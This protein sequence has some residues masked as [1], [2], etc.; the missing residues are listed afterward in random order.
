MA[1]HWA[2]RAEALLRGDFFSAPARVKMRAMRFRV[3]IATADLA[4]PV[5]ASA[6]VAALPRVI[7]RPLLEAMLRRRRGLK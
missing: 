7:E 3:H 5:L 4:A 2:R 1:S 6:N